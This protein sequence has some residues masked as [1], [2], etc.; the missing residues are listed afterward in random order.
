MTTPR[1][2]VAAF[3]AF[4]DFKAGKSV[5]TLRA[6]RN[7]F[8]S[9]AALVSKNLDRP[10][11][12]LTVADVL[13]KY[14]L[15]SAF[16]AFATTRSRAS[17][18]RCWSTWNT[19]AAFLVGDDILDANPMASVEKSS[20]GEPPGPPK[21]I[22]PEEVETMLVQLA[23][24]DPEDVDGWRQ[25]DLAIVLLGLLLGLRSGE[26]SAL[27]IGDFSPIKDDSGAMTVTVRGKGNK[28]RVMTAEASLIAILEIYLKSRIARF[29]D[30]VTRAKKGRSRIWS[31]IEEKEPLLVGADGER[32][33]RGTLQYRT[34]R[35]YRQAGIPSVRG[36]NTH[37][38]RHT[39]AITLASEGVPVNVLAGLLGHSS[40]NTALKYL[41][42]S[43]RATRAA[44][45][46]NPIYNMADR[47]SPNN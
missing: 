28:V 37:R 41:E 20:Q 38:L 2:L 27:N 1:T 39:F 31:Q 22:E 29:P 13:D 35:A 4:L 6:Y 26:L 19:F 11:E 32:I 24:P 5:N 10:I 46:V 16:G 18:H 33:T 3:D 42:A 23:L 9:I 44:T 36:A 7:D 43:G 34:K 30:H 25:R 21:S 8:A 45:N 17:M 14:V 47:I 15:R 12:D 40:L